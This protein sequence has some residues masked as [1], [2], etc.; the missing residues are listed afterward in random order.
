ME[1]E[2]QLPK[3]LEGV[4]SVLNG[5]IEAMNLAKEISGITP[6]KAVFGTVSVILTMIRVS[7]VVVC[8]LNTD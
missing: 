7:V 3:E 4:A 5:A 2:P 6:A 8:W 1:T